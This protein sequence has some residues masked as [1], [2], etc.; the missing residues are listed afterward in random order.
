MLLIDNHG[1]HLT[2][3]FIL[4]ANKNHIRPLPFIAHLTHCMQP[5][6]VGIFQ[7]YKHWHDVAIQEAVAEFDLEYSLP[8]LCRDLTKIRNNTFKNSTIR[9]AFENPE[10]GLSIRK[11]AL[12]NFTSMP[13]LKKMEIL[14]F[15]YVGST[16]GGIY[17]LLSRR[18]RILR[19]HAFVL[20]Q[21]TMLS[22]D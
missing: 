10:F 20:E 2:P 5:L 4:L 8:R 1:S 21:S 18:Q 19:F 3:E 22:K 17:E 16:N 11:N 13:I 7:P 15:V 14:A 12:I 9:S 6:D